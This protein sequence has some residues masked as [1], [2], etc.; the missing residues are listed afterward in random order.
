MMPVL[1]TAIASA[2]RVDQLADWPT[3]PRACAL[4]QTPLIR[5]AISASE[6]PAMGS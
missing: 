6:L 5:G 2:R 4:E 3:A 1:R